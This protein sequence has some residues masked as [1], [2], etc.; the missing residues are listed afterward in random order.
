M[1]E[2]ERGFKGIW[3][4]AEIWLN[5]DLTP[6]DKVIYAEIDSLD[7]GEGCFASN[8]HIA[9]FCKCSV[10]KVATAIT[11][12]KEKRY[13]DLVSFNGRCRIL[14][15]AFQKVNGRLSK[16]E[17]QTFK[18]CKADFQ[19]MKG[20]SSKVPSNSINTM[21]KIDEKNSLEN[22]LESK[23]KKEKV[24]PLCTAEEFKSFSEQYH[25]GIEADAFLNWMDEHGWIYPDGIRITSWKEA[26]C[27]WADHPERFR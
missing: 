18:K 16:N 8:E 1:G 2:D 15:S 11:K 23:R 3:I 4:P 26:A 10:T 6:L 21:R 14:K 17:R 5:E 13:I 27:Y 7:T 22:S 19:K 12:L 24:K 20:V 9:A 25:L